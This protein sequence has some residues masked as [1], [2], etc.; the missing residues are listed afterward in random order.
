[1]KKSWLVLLICLSALFLWYTVKNQMGVVVE[2]D[3]VNSEETSWIQL[4]WWEIDKAYVDKTIKL[5]ELA[6]MNN[7]AYGFLTVQETSLHKR[8]MNDIK[9]QVDYS[10]WFSDDRLIYQFDAQEHSY[11][12]P[13]AVENSVRLDSPECDDEKLFDTILCY[14][15]RLNWLYGPFQNVFGKGTQFV[16]TVS[17]YQWLNS[18]KVLDLWTEK[19]FPLNNLIYLMYHSSDMKN[20][21]AVAEWDDSLYKDVMMFE[22][23]S[24]KLIKDWPID[25]LFFDGEKLYTVTVNNATWLSNISVIDVST[26]KEIFVMNDVDIGEVSE[27]VIEWDS[28]FI[29]YVDVSFVQEKEYYYM[30][31]FDL[32]TKEKK[33][34]IETNLL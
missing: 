10:V 12:L 8:I 32:K 7:E 6:S 20:I 21:I 34:K 16:Y 3:E 9:L 4:E 24:K 26:Y 22:N 28:L 11:L 2:K 15:P 1:M 31:E 17:A 25:S 5:M 13:Y 33:W 19:E 30:E 14:M 18:Q 27:F 29:N 23:W